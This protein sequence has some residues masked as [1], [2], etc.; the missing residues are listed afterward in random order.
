MEWKVLIWGVQRFQKERWNETR[1]GRQEVMLIRIWSQVNW[2]FSDLLTV[3]ISSQLHSVM[4][5]SS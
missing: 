3:C 1:K 4:P 2:I 5:H